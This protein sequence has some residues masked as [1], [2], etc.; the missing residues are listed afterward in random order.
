M[1]MNTKS[2]VTNYHLLPDRHHV[3]N[4]WPPVGG[5]L[6]GGKPVEP[7]LGSSTP[8]LQKS[9]DYYGQSTSYTQHKPV[10]RPTDMA[11]VNSNNYCYKSSQSRPDPTVNIAVI[12]PTEYNSN[13]HY[14]EQSVKYFQHPVTNRWCPP[15]PPQTQTSRL[16]HQDPTTMFN[17]VI[18][19]H[20]LTLDVHFTFKVCSLLKLG[21][22]HRS[23][24]V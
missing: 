16:Y 20:R 1:E 19:C 4:L 5:G 14:G 23:L 10:P 17:Q 7:A 8:M 15:A 22:L 18:C 2:N 24:Q 11:N 13:S 9:P 12:P 6:P 21:K 3:R